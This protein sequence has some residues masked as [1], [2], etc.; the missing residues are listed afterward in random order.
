LIEL[1]SLNKFEKNFFILGS[2]IIYKYSKM[3][4][5]QFLIDYQTYIYR[6]SN[7]ILSCCGLYQYCSS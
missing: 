1:L 7:C 2:F 5:N 4:V 3:L 6:E